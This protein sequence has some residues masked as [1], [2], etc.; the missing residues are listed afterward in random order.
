MSCAV[1]SL[2]AVE[3]EVGITADNWLRNYVL[4]ARHEVVSR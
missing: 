3:R 4:A 1:A 2:A